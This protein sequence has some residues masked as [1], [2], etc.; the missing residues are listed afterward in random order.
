L[1][2]RRRRG[3]KGPRVYLFAARK[4]GRRKN[5]LLSAREDVPP[6]TEELPC[7]DAIYEIGGE[8]SKREK[9]ESS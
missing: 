8:G 9:E 6:R 1:T 4:G 5:A 2:S 7:P 3:T